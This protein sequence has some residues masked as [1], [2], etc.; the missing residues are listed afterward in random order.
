MIL[1]Y[2]KIVSYKIYL[3]TRISYYIPNI[4]DVKYHIIIICIIKS[5]IYI[6]IYINYYFYIND[7]EII[8][9]IEYGIY[10]YFLLH[11]R[12]VLITP[13]QIQM[14]YIY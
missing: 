6:Y 1:E 11:L 13:N 7:I 5:Y 8:T 14:L 2:N 10:T 4:S 12:E 3:V 9:I